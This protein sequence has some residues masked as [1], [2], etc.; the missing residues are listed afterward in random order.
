MP[1]FF[2]KRRLMQNAEGRMHEMM[3]E[4]TSLKNIFKYLLALGF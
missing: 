3:R 1:F 2:T 4:V